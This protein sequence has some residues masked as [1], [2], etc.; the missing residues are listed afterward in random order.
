MTAWGS[1]GWITESINGNYITNF[2]NKLLGGSSYI[3]LSEELKNS[4][5]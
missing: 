2:F 5:K 4:R 3:A 1:S